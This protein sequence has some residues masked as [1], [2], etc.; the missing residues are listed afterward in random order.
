MLFKKIQDNQIYAPTSGQYV[1][2][3]K[4]NDTTFSSGLM[5]PGLGIYPKSSCIYS[6][7]DGEIT[8]IFPTGHAIGI[9]RKDNLEILIHIGIET[10]KL[11]GKGF[12][13]LTTLNKKVKKG[14]KLISFDKKLIIDENMDP[15][16]IM[17]ITNFNEFHTEIKVTDSS[18]VTKEVIMYAEKK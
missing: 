9:K 18:I 5:G 14:D 7:I 2:L 1:P 10:V 12:N 6:P 11:A 4:I 8:M 3:E 16:V 15:T 13:I 17:I